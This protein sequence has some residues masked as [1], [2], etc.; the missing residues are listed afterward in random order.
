MVENLD[1]YAL[2]QVPLTH[3][4]DHP[5]NPRA[6]LGDLKE[7]SDSIVTQGILQPLVAVP[8]DTE[9][10][11]VIVAGHRR[12]AAA[13]LAGV[14]TVPV[15]IRRDLGASAQ[16]EVMLVENVQRADLAPVEQARAL[17]SLVDLGL[18]QRDIAARTG[19]AQGTV[20]KR[21]ALLD[22]PTSIA[23]QVDSG[24]ISVKD[25]EVLASAARKNADPK[26]IDAAA[27]FV[28]AGVKGDEAVKRAEDDARRS[29]KAQQSR[30]KAE[31]LGAVAV[32]S[33]KTDKVHN[34][35]KIG[36]TEAEVQACTR[37]GHPVWFIVYTH[38]GD[39]SLYCSAPRKHPKPQGE[40]DAA[41]AEKAAKDALASALV[42]GGMAR[43]EASKSWVK[44]CEQKKSADLLI[45]RA[46]FGTVD[47]LFR[48]RA[49]INTSALVLLGYTPD[50]NNKTWAANEFHRLLDG[51][52]V[53]KARAAA[54]LVVA[55]MEADLAYRLKVGTL[56]LGPGSA[57]Y[58]DL[59]GYTLSEAEAARVGAKA[60]APGLT[61]IAG[62]PDGP[63]DDAVSLGDVE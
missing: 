40:Q 25:G 35:P 43:L 33:D 47:M 5:D 3:L 39:L 31:T 13:R 15:V 63:D 41:K 60:P 61:D 9:G 24:G 11:Y 29:N 26:V 38:T 46:L 53:E 42:I 45:W 22:L 59:I 1:T 57:A 37:L 19:I 32:P 52:P 50:P 34:L 10:S 49:D 12:A 18:S 44:K 14:D 30:G 58:L 28:A 6:S 54:A 21:L 8:S 16:V 20:S 7:L 62:I 17:Q 55:E 51:K 4:L 56:Q 2:V 23:R 36:A 48:D 27:K